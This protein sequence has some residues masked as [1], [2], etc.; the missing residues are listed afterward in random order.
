MTAVNSVI[1]IGAMHERG[2]SS[3]DGAGCV[4]G[5]KMIDGQAAA[6][7]RQSQPDR[8]APTRGMLCGGFGGFGGGGGGGGGGGSGTHTETSG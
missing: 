2:G 1:L 7:G 4:G 3:P 8:L 5:E 6:A